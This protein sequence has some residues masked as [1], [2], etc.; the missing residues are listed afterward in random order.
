MIKRIKLKKMAV[1]M[2]MSASFVF[3]MSGCGSSSG[4][5]TA[6]GADKATTEIVTEATTAEVTEN[7]KTEATTGNKFLPD[8][9]IPE[10]SIEK[11]E[12]PDNEGLRFVHDMRVGVNLGN[13]FDAY[14]DGSSL[15][16]DMDTETA[17]ISTKATQET[18]KAYHEAGFDTIRIPVSWHNHVSDDYTISEKWLSRVQEVVDWAIDDGMY[19]IINIHHDNHLEADGFYP[20]NEHLDKSK[21]YITRIWEQLSER[22]KDYDEKL[23]FESMNEPRLVGH[24]YEWWYPANTAVVKESMEC[25]NQLN[26]VFVDTV[27]ASG[28]NNAVRYLMC[29]G[30]DASPDGALDAVYRVPEDSAGPEHHIIISVHAYTPYDFAL[31]TNGTRDFSV[32]NKKGTGD[33]DSFMEKL[34]QKYI[35]DG[36]PVVIGEFGAVD[37]NK[38]IQERV[39]FAAYYIASARARGMTAL[40]W[41]NSAFSGNG[42]SLGLYYRIGGYFVY[43]DIVDALMKYVDMY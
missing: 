3:S 18:I 21:H 35:K 27:R 33:I 14:I 31:N 1:T 23:I 26:Q 42:E 28:G 24:Q 19:V 8:T 43:K 17:W 10:L 25:I 38:N 37:K 30:Y 22:F 39:D 16:N 9:T 12:I 15:K 32:K 40:W 7:E 20:D 11:Y 4:S 13:T 29:P 5:T 36:T 2:L 34:Y 6:S 41:D